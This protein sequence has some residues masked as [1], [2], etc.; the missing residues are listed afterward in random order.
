MT[1]TSHP[2]P[3]PGD[4]TRGA[5]APSSRG[6]PSLAPLRRD[7]ILDAVEGCIIDSGIDSVSFAR[8]AS[9]A[10]VRTSIVPHY[11][12]SKEALMTAMVDRV[13]GRV[14]L[15][16]D[17]A[18][19]GLDGRPLLDRLLDVLF[20]GQLT[21]APVVVVLDQLRASA[22]FNEP[23]RT[24]LVAMYRHFEDLAA[25]ALDEIYPD[26]EPAQRRAVAYALLC[27]GDANNSFRGT[28]FP[29]RYDD[30]ARAAAEVLLSAL[31]SGARPNG[32]S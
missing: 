18:L 21:A 29:G 8:V 7:Q 30:A 28:G 15:L 9:R 5:R 6:R 12:G 20:G 2:R 27:L 14:Q 17:T 16:L 1:E 24:R 31:E 10:G 22:Y 26:A 19:E 3:R 13:L 11:F 23:T 32:T 4:R 25:A